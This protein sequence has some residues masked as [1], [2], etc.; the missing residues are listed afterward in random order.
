LQQEIA[1]GGWHVL[2]ADAETVF[3]KDPAHIWPE[4]IK[5]AATRQTRDFAAPLPEYLSRFH[6]QQSEL[7]APVE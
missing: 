6:R 3:D 1:R 7:S 5:R 4:L 2:P